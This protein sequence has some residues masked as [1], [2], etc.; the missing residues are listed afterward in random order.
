MHCPYC[1]YEETKVIDSRE[2]TDANSIK[3]RRECLKC[4]KR[5]TT[6]EHVESLD[7]V[8][9]KKDGSRQEYDRDKIRKSMLI[10]CQK[11]PVT[12]EQLEQAINKIEFKIK[13]TNS[14]EVQSQEIGHEVMK[15][16]KKLDK[17]AF[18]RFASVYKEF[19]D[20]E[21]FNEELKQLM[22]T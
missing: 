8:V 3:R 9:I 13:N 10:A 12:E 19:K 14:T 2:V 15:A 17:V 11:R 20:L 5:F 1:K 4:A 16:L 6:K 22:K 21:E 7:I 18:V